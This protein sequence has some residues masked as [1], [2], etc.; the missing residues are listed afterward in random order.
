MISGRPQLNAQVDLNRNFPLGFGL[1]A[2]AQPCSEVYKGQVGLVRGRVT[3]G[4]RY[5]RGT[6]GTR[7]IRFIGCIRVRYQVGLVIKLMKMK[8]LLM[9]TV[10]Y[11]YDACR[12]LK[13]FTFNDQTYFKYLDE[14]YFRHLCQSRKPK[15][16]S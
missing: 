12:I 9:I 4:I 5:R 16:C 6:T 7:G 15:H 11:K 3:R 1:G 8:L 14:T 13:F 2:D 10:W